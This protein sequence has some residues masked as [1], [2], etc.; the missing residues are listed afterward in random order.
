MNTPKSQIM[1]TVGLVVDK[2]TKEI[3]AHLENDLGLLDSAE[4]DLKIMAK[5]SSILLKLLLS[6]ACELENIIDRLNH[7]IERHV[8]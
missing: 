5:D 7:A 3:D 6:Y 2:L 4:T 8:K 1:Q